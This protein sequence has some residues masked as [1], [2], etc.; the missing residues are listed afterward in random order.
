M[1]S[2]ALGIFQIT[3]ANEGS[4]YS[5]MWH[6][7][8]DRVANPVLWILCQQL[9]HKWKSKLCFK[10]IRMLWLQWSLLFQNH[11]HIWGIADAPFFQNDNTQTVTFGVTF[12]G[13]IGI[14]CTGKPL[15][16]KT[17]WHHL[18]IIL[19]FCKG[20]YWTDA[21]HVAGTVGNVLP[22]SQSVTPAASHAAEFQGICCPFMTAEWRQTQQHYTWNY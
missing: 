10:Q 18:A 17:K 7:L 19:L 4:Y 6:L 9:W 8:P 11:Y 13:I 3:K 21:Q 15:R 2:K 14:T 20:F 12:V 5:F 22:C 16:S 1:L